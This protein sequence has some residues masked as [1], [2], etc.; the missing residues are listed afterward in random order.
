MPLYESAHMGQ[1]QHWDL[2]WFL[3]SFL[4]HCTGI[5]Q[6]AQLPNIKVATVLLS[7]AFAYDIFWVFISPL[8]FH[9]SV[10]IA[11][12][13]V[14]LQPPRMT[15]AM[16]VSESGREY[17]AK[18][19]DDTP[20]TGTS[21]K[22]RG[23]AESRFRKRSKYLSYPYTNSEPRLKSFPAETEESKTPSPTPKAKASSRTSN[24]KNGSL[25]ST[26]LGGTRF[27]NNWY[28][29]FISCSKMSSSPKFIGASSSDLLSG[30]MYQ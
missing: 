21:Q 6:L 2:G 18:N 27:Q 13:R 19:T 23:G 9:E 12:P 5:L 16:D 29:K 3:L 28:R 7:Y 24:P 20:V 11:N 1:I 15:G 4:K 8:I 30:V 10:M 25:S 22:T 26:K 14:A 17:G